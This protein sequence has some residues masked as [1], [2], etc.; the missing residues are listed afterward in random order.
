GNWLR[1]G[2]PPWRPVRGGTDP[3]HEPETRSNRWVSWTYF[4]SVGPSGRRSEGPPHRITI[5]NYTIGVSARGGNG[6]GDQLPGVIALIPLIFLTLLIPS[7]G[8]A[9]R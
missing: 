7:E 9:S 5:Q 3:P 8:G 2:R 6:Q 4:V 1:R